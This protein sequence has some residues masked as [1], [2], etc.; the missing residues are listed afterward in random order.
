MWARPPPETRGAFVSLIREIMVRILYQ[1]MSDQSEK[2]NTGEEKLER[3]IFYSKCFL[4]IYPVDAATFTL[5]RRMINSQELLFM[6]FND[7]IKN[8]GFVKRELSI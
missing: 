5:K 1:P 2:A 6:I 4:I 8:K 3:V 7:Y